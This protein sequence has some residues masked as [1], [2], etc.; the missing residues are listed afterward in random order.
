[1][2]AM[3]TATARQRLEVVFLAAHRRAE[4]ADLYL[5]RLMDP[6]ES[7]LAEAIA[8]SLPAGTRASVEPRWVAKQLIG[9]LLA[10]ILH[11]EVLRGG[12]S[13]DPSRDQYLSQVVEVIAGGV[14]RMATMDRRT[15]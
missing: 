1:M 11:E 15:L 7:G 2:T 9:S 6:T 10:Y 8:K 13:S 4:W 14:E 3:A 5:S 12:G